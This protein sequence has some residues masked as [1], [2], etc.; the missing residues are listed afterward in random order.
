M[1][2]IQLTE[3]D[4]CIELGSNSIYINVHSVGSPAQT[5]VYI[6]KTS[7]YLQLHSLVAYMNVQICVNVC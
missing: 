3:Y 7:A 2:K 6:C 4:V 5:I 1:Y